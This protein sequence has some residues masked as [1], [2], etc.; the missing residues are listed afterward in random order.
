MFMKQEPFMRPGR[1]RKTA[2]ALRLQAERSKE[3]ARK[4]QERRKQ[5]FR[6]P[7]AERAV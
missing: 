1:P 5:L 2:E 6:P 3:E 4:G 7:L